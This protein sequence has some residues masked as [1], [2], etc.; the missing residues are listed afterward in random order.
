MRELKYYG[1]EWREGT[2]FLILLSPLPHPSGPHF[3]NLSPAILDV[4]ETPL[5]NHPTN[6][7]PKY[8]PYLVACLK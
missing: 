4:L 6:Y 7:R 8:K 1:W 2:K 5:S 3:N